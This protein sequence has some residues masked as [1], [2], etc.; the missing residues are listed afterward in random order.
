M[1]KCEH[2]S[3]ISE[4]R[5]HSVIRNDGGSAIDGTSKVSYHAAVCSVRPVGPPHEASPGTRNAF[6]SEG[7]GSRSS[8]FASGP[9]FISMHTRPRSR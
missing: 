4:A 5:L 9:V 2:L 3:T 8:S 7:M 1:S 6:I